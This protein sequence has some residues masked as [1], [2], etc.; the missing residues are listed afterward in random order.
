M[1]TYAECRKKLR[2]TNTQIGGLE[3]AAAKLQEEHGLGENES[4]MAAIAAEAST[5]QIGRTSFINDTVK[6]V[7][8]KRGLGAKDEVVAPV[9][10]V[11]P[12]KK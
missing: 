4:Y 3:E 10:P 7:T 12:K 6:E 8:P 11:E 2:I 9:K 1:A 5:L